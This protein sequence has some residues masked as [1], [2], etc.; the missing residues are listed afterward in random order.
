MCGDQEFFKVAKAAFTYLFPQF[1]D[2]LCVIVMGL[3]DLGI[4]TDLGRRNLD[5]VWSQPTCS[6]VYTHL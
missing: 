6:E 4:P 5:Q 2:Q 1:S 3:D